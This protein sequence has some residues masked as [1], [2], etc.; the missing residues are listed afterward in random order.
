[1]AVAA[2]WFIPPCTEGELSLLLHVE[3]RWAARVKKSEINT[4]SFFKMRTALSF[5]FLR[6]LK[7]IKNM[8]GLLIF[9]GIMPTFALWLI[10]L[11]L[12]YAYI[13]K[14]AIELFIL[15]VGL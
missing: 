10:I 3:Q 14:H 8:K 2:F 13:K 1:M 11:S 9:S 4:F 15:I 5:T 12:L 7:M 6:F